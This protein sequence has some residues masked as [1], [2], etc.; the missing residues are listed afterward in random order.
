MENPELKIPVIKK[1]LIGLIAVVFIGGISILID[2]DTQ[3]ANMKLAAMH[4]SP[5]E[6]KKLSAD[7]IRKKSRPAIQVTEAYLQNEQQANDTFKGK[8]LYIAG[9]IADIKNNTPEQPDYALLKGSKNDIYVQCYL[10][11]EQVARQLKPGMN[12]ILKGTCEG[13]STN[14][15]LKNCKLV[16]VE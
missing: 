13:L 4:A 9:T 7:R 12:V 8:V 5:S 14:V 11:E 16:L 2:K 1:I 6:K 15:L 3:A 10:V